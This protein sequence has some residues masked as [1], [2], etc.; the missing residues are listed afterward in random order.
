MV[1]VA[2]EILL[3]IYSSAINNESNHDDNDRCGGG[4]GGAAEMCMNNMIRNGGYT[5]TD[6]VVE[7]FET[8][9]ASPSTIMHHDEQAHF[10]FI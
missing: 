5:W 3:Q 10:D 6:Q 9:T 2:V 7:A 8:T 1:A 4:D